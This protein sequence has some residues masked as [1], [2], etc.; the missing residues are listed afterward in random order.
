[1]RLRLYNESV[2]T[3]LLFKGQ[4]MY[5]S[6]DEDDNKKVAM[7]VVFTVVALVVVSAIGV[8]LWSQAKG[9]AA[10]AGASSTASAAPAAVAGM[11]GGTG[12]ST[13]GSLGLNPGAVGTGLAPSAPLAADDGGANN[14]AK[15][16]AKNDARIEVEQGVVKFFFASG[17]ADLA[18]GAVAALAD[19]AKGVAAGQKAIVS[20]YTDASGDPVKNAALAKTRAFA[21]R[22]ALVA[23]GVKL[24]N[25]ELRK[26]A[27]TT[28]NAAGSS[29]DARRVDVRLE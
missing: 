19:V 6:D 22:D 21:V 16:D 3:G 29:A 8:G 2:Q 23:A 20:G 26:P 25:V 14:G 5:S 24:D 12:L 18:A 1:M 28:A 11:G 17:K 13:S 7:F 15:N 4:R 10:K 27:A 9:K